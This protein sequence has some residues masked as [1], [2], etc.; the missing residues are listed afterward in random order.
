MIVSVIVVLVSLL[1]QLASYRRKREMDRYNGELLQLAE[2]ARH[3]GSLELIDQGDE[4][5]SDFVPRIVAAT[6]NG[7]ISAEQFDMFHFTYDAVEDAIR[8]RETQLLRQQ[9]AA[10][11][12][13]PPA[14]RKG[15]RKRQADGG[16]VS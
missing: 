15:R 5:L 10:S 1:V 16:A 9:A 2:K 6:R 7:Q 8:D 4:D 11:A 3:A 14:R 13:Q 12:A